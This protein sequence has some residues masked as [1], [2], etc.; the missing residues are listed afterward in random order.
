MKMKNKNWASFHSQST[1]LGSKYHL[2][3]KKN[4]TKQTKKP[5]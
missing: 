4:N 2:H 3:K 1:D 5:N